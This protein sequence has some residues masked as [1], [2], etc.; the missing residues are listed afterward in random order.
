M[1]TV[2]RSFSE[3]ERLKDNFIVTEEEN[4]IQLKDSKIIFKGTN[5]YVFLDKDAQLV[6]TTITFLG[7]NS[8]LYIDKTRNNKIQLKATLYNDS[9]VSF[10]EGCSF[11]KPL[12]LIASEAKDIIVGKDVMFSSGCWIRNSDVHLIY[13]EY[14]RRINE[15]KSILIGDHVWI[16]QNASI[17]K[18]SYIGSGA[19]IGLG[20]IVAKKI[21]SNS[22]NV[23]NP[24]KRIRENVFWDRQSSHFFTEEDTRQHEFYETDSSQYIFKATDN[25]EKWWE[26]IT[27][28]PTFTNQSEIMG[29]IKK[30]IHLRP[31]VVLDSLN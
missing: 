4:N 28:K 16:G 3:K 14:Q 10:N 1:D 29:F 15:S 5:N 7:S 17:L 8:V 20:S 25:L 6:D 13:D 24:I 26:N 23:G 21:Q 27:A 2:I 11:N 30:V 31:L 9:L 19:I 18:G 12:F 22:I